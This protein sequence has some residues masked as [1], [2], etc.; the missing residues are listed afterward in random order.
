MIM[1]D[2]PGWLVSETGDAHRAVAHGDTTALITVRRTGP[3]DIVIDLGG[4]A[5]HVD[6]VDPATLAGPDDLTAVLK[7]TGIVARVANPSLWD[8]LAAAIMRQVIQASHARARYARFCTAYGDAVTDSGVTTSR[9][10]GP[11]RIL[12]LSDA[13]FHQVGAAF[14]MPA[15]REAA[16]AYLNRGEKWRA[17]PALEL[18]TLL[19][20]VPRI[21][22]WTAK[23]AVADCTNNFEIYP[24]TDLAVVTWAKQLNPSREWPA[25]APAFK[26]AW[27]EVAGNQL[28]AWTLLTLAWGISH[29]KPARSVAS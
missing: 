23:A 25:G 29:G 1:T 22:P 7:S 20:E 21:G 16:R 24:Y 13:D 3:D 18:V 9:F 6:Y 4:A 28:S 26:A 17:V 15:L 11:D 5:A 14:P 27:E 2:H 10:P 8:A 12:A 19:Q